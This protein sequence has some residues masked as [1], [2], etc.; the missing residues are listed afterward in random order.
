MSVKS[1]FRA[2]LLVTLVSFNASAQQAPDQFGSGPL[3]L[4]KNFDVVTLYD[5]VYEFKG[6]T[7]S[8]DTDAAI[9]KEVSNRAGIK[10]GDRYDQVQA[11]MAALRLRRIDGVRNATYR[12]QSRINPDGVTLVFTINL[13]K[14][15]LKGEESRGFL[16]AGETDELP[17]LYQND[18]SVLKMTLNAGFGGFT[19]LQPWFGAPGNFTKNN[20][21][22]QNPSI[23]ANTGASASWF[24]TY[25]EYGLIGSTQLGDS[26][27]YAY[28][29]A[30]AMTTTAAGRDIFWDGG[31][32]QTNIEKLY[33]GLM[34]AGTQG[35]S[36]SISVGRQN[37]SLNDGFLISQYGSQ[38]NAGP[39][40]GIYLAPRT[41]QDS[42]AL[43]QIQWSDWTFKGFYLNPNEYEPV[44][45]NTKV[46]G[47]NLRY[48]FTPSFY[49][50]G[51]YIT[52]PSSDSMNR[53]PGAA[54][55]T[56]A[57]L[58][59]FAGHIRWADPKV[60]K[61]LWVESEYAQQSNTN[62]SMDAYGGYA[63]IGYLAS[64]LTWTPSLSY[65]Y[66]TFSGDNPNTDKYERFDPL[67]SGGIGE[68]LQGVSMGKILT[69]ANRTVHRVRLN[70]APVPV[71]NLTL[72]YYKNIANQLNNFGGNPALSTLT[73]TDLGQELQFIARWAINSHFFFQGVIGY[74]MPGNAIVAATGN[75]AKPW[76]TFQAQLFWNW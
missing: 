40:A 39:R 50:D 32:T 13:N 74:A 55:L 60:L 42:S 51:S 35:D 15:V 56:R 38:Y 8:L 36:A 58:Q 34:Y 46:L 5:V 65:R 54:S 59:T 33:A 16:S 70:V 41:T 26:P 48:T 45:S 44:E 25:V 21:L 2:T 66:A 24:E 68:W 14:P 9:R 49:L 76:T 71:L 61:G 75:T 20:P 63:T 3:T 27:F 62:Y 19:D 23:G 12:L 43:T 72:D 18:R 47:G 53:V 10:P 52:V 73:S 67:F 22:V 37:F 28:G 7:G 11:D 30:S 69:Q 57:G 29:A 64:N 31:R 6:S 17:T 4:P 1:I